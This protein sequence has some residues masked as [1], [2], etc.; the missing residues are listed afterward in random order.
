M[1]ASAMHPAAQT[2]LLIEKGR[3][4]LGTIMASHSLLFME[5]ETG[6]TL[7]LEVARRNFL[8]FIG[9]DDTH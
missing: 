6:A 8:Q 3:I 5:F 9:G 2:D 1:I 4:D 7:L